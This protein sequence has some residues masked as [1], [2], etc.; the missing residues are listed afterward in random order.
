MYSA[1]FTTLTSLACFMDISHL[2]FDSMF[3]RLLF[4][5]LT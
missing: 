1:S 5:T 3:P 4:V 2:N